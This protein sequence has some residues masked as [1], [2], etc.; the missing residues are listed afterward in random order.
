MFER[1]SLYL[2]MN[3][4]S[5]YINDNKQ[6]ILSL[7]LINR[8]FYRMANSSTR[9]LLNNIKS[10]F[11][12]SY[13][14]R[15][16][17]KESRTNVYLTKRYITTIFF[18]ND[19]KIDESINHMKNCKLTIFVPYEVQFTNMNFEILKIKN[20]NNKKK[21]MMTILSEVPNSSL[22]LSRFNRKRLN[23]RVSEISCKNCIFEKTV[24]KCSK[25]SFQKCYIV[26]YL[27]IE[28]FRELTTQFLSEMFYGVIFSK[29]I[30][31]FQTKKF[32]KTISDVTT[33]NN[34]SILTLTRG[35][36]S[37][38]SLEYQILFSYKNK[39]FKVEIF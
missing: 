26:K 19:I 13:Y 24:F 11:K 15:K 25:F 21:E 1:L 14:Q 18:D 35:Q 30:N 6:H 22:I 10:N 23:V 34:K 28:Y 5:F 16:V 2:F 9:Y 4:I 37:M 20:T 7:R 32:S 27:G 31:H 12:I 3:I 38:N 39:G 8:W 17:Q 33:N 36:N 29:N